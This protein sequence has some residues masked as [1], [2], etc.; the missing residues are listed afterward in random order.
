MY[1]SLIP[2]RACLR[3]C[4]A[5]AGRILPILVHVAECFFTCRVSL[6][7]CGCFYG[8]S[9]GC[10]LHVDMWDAF[11]DFIFDLQLSTAYIYQDPVLQD[12]VV[13]CAV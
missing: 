2:E 10:G 8:Y 6:V 5:E 9:Y 4:A 7:V 12:I 11:T 3:F 13:H 1:L